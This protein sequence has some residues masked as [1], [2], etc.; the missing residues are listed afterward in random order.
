MVL[1]PK[2]KVST[3]PFRNGESFLFQELWIEEFGLITRSTVA[4]DGDNRFSRAQFFGQANCSSDVDPGGT[5]EAQSFFLK[6]LKANRQCLIIR[7][8]EGVIHD[9]V[10][11]VGGDPSLAR[12]GSPPVSYTH[13]T[14]PTICSV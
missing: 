6:Q 3:Q 11:Q 2:A 12:D 5:P 9:G 14:L 10:F 13:L 7:N 4:E 8:L 1:N